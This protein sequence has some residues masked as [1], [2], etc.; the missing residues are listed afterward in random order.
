MNIPSC[1]QCLSLMVNHQMPAHIQEHSRKVARIA[2]GLG[3]CLNHQGIGLNVELLEAGGLLHD[4]AKAHCLRTGEN[5]ALVGGRMV[6]QMGYPRVARI[7]EDHVNIAASDLQLPVNESVLVNYAD[8]RV[9]HTEVVSL[10]ER[11]GDLV[12]RYG[13]TIQ[14]RARLT[15][16]L[17]LFARLEDVIFSDLRIQ[18]HEI[19]AW[20]DTSPWAAEAVP[21]IV[22]RYS[23]DGV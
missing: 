21:A 12:E 18:P 1:Q 20:V 16:Y 15:Q 22:G 13:V 10:Q 8:K 3:R 9:K 4:I 11:F 5:H 23:S 2:V 7:V 19:V 6:R 17:S 14:R